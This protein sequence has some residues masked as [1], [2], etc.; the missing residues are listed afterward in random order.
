M[1]L[2]HQG[3]APQ[4][5]GF[6]VVCEASDARPLADELE[7]L[8]W[9]LKRFPRL[10]GGPGRESSVG[11]HVVTVH[12][13]LVA[14]HASESTQHARLFVMFLDGVVFGHVQGAGVELAAAPVDLT[15]RERSHGTASVSNRTASLK[16]MPNRWQPGVSG[17]RRRRR[18]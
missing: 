16:E 11:R 5:L 3:A 1:V 2:G 7:H 15:F 17:R 10:L 12:G 14:E 13:L 18:R 4:H 8:L 9:R 6:T